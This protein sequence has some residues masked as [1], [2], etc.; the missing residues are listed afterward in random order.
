MSVEIIAYLMDKIL[1]ERDARTHAMQENKRLR[2]D[3]D[4]LNS[5]CTQLR[6]ELLQHVNDGAEK[7][8]LDTPDKTC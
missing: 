7:K 3:I 5:K 1:E 2:S 8:A 4:L 6:T